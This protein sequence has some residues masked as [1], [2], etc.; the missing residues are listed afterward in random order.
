MTKSKPK[1]SK[2]TSRWVEL[3]GYEIMPK[4]GEF[5]EVTEWSNGEGFDLHISR[6]EQAISLT[7]GEFSALQA[8][9]GDW[10][11]KDIEDEE[12]KVCPYVV[13]AGEGTSYCKL[14]V[15]TADLLAKLT[16]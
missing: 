5:L 12:D 9:F 3:E 1:E 4:P 11:D 7:W 15:Q 8:A 16:G 13:T 10:I 14:G 2:R 6:G